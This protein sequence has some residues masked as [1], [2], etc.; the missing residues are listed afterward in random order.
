M[1]TKHYYKIGRN[2]RYEEKDGFNYFEAFVNLSKYSRLRRFCT[3]PE[4]FDASQMPQK[5]NA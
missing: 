2:N 3:K 5:Q 4:E 1:Q